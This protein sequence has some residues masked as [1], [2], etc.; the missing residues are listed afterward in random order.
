MNK[1]AL[2]AVAILALS[3]T[4]V[5]AAEPP[6][7][8]RAKAPA[9]APETVYNWSGFFIGGHI[10][11]AWASQG[12]T[13]APPGSLAF[14]VG[15]AFTQ[16]HLSGLLGG[17]QGG[18]NWQSGNWV[19]GV[20]GDYSWSNLTS[21]AT[22][23]SVALPAFSTTVGVKVRDL[24]LAT[25]RVGYAL[26]NWLFYVNGGG[27]WGQASSSAI[28][29]DAGAF[30]ESTSSSTS[31]RGWVVGGGAEWGFARNWSAKIEYDHIDFGTLDDAISTSRG[32]TTFIN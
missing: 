14:P 26:N 27:A 3:A 20:E 10:G 15:T 22:T 29:T 12:E 25:G 21:N 18:A 32:T 31:R 4:G 19:L 28:V 7:R 6:T 1:L 2:L 13:E 9:R 5:A 23:P 16:Q 24:A 11:G 30:Y 8:I 17:V